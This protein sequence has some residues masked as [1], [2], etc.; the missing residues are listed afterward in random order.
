VEA[1]CQCSGSRDSRSRESRR[2]MKL[3]I[4]NPVAPTGDRTMIMGIVVALA[5]A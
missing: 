2:H 5:R 4:G 3:G 1:S